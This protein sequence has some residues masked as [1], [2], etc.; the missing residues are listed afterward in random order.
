NLLVGAGDGDALIFRGE[1]K[2]R[3]RWSWDRLT[4]MV[5][6]LQQAYRA[7]GIGAG[8]RIA[9]MMPSLPETVACML[10]ATSSG[11]I[12]S[13]CSPDFGEQGVLDRFGQIGP[14]LFICCD[15]YW[16]NGKKQDV[17]DKVRAVVA[18][19]GV[20]CLVVPYAGDAPALAASLP[21]G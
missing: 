3:D 11:A 14:K 2:V 17:A 12:W 18:K 16:Y 4:A 6:R 21:D 1:D 13:S 8:D 9:A 7:M 5:S 15:G 10:A 20:P 19:L